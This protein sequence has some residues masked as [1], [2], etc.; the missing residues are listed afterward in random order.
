MATVTVEAFPF[1]TGQTLELDAFPEGS[2]TA[3]ASAQAMTEATNRKGLYTAT[4]TDPPAGTYT[5]HVYRSG[6]PRQLLGGDYMKVDS[7]DTK[8]T[9]GWAQQLSDEAILDLSNAAAGA[10][11]GGI[12]W[13][14][15]VRDNG[16]N[17]I[18]ECAVWVS[19]DAAGNNVV[20]GTLY[21]D[22]AGNATFNLDAGT[23]YL[24]RNHSQHNFT[25]PQTMTVS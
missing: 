16:G 1:A 18:A 22:D 2:D 3:F 9:L 11:V 8:V 19:T 15:C 17:P 6:A 13:T 21:T 24:W 7:G 25:N 20:A 10:G 23:Y 5:I 14:V 12:E 4:L